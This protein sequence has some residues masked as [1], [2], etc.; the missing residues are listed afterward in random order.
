MYV[1]RYLRCPTN[2]PSTDCGRLVTASSSGY[3][4]SIVNSLQSM[5]QWEDYFGAPE[6]S[7]LGV[8]N[9]VPVRSQSA[10]PIYLVDTDN[11]QVRR[12]VGGPPLRALHV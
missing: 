2:S 4:G 8:F 1:L 12:T 10:Y 7:A 6:G 11:F 3:D 9:A 5:Y